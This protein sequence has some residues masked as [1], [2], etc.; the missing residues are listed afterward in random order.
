[1]ALRPAPKRTAHDNVPRREE[2]RYLLTVLEAAQKI[3]STSDLETLL[4]KIVNEIAPVFGCMQCFVWLCEDASGDLVLAGAPPAKGYTKGTRL[5]IGRE[6]LVGHVAATGR[7]RYTPD[8]RRDPLYV[9]ASRRFDTR[10]ELDLP[11]ICNNRVIGVLNTE[12][13]YV[14]GF[15]VRQRS[16]LKR[17]ADYTATAVE[18]A[19]ASTRDQAEKQEARELQMR[20]LPKGPLVAGNYEL[21]GRCVPSGVV[22]GDWFDYFAIGS[23]RVAVALA[24]V[25]GKGLAAALLMSSS[26]M[27][28]RACMAQTSRPSEVL[29]M[30][31]RFLVDD[32]PPAR[33]VTLVFGVL[34][35]RTGEF[36]F[37]NA[38]HP[39]PLLISDS[40]TF[41]RTQRGLPL[42]MRESEYDDYSVT[43]TP[44]S[45]LL[46]YSDGIWEASNSAEDEFGAAHL[47]E[48]SAQEWATPDS[49]LESVFAFTGCRALKDDATAVMLRA[50]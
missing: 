13:K 27:L 17:L 16:A 19:R 10:S 31:N 35:L 25:A 15:D 14:D 36:M 34:D 5:R 24:D 6:G 21:Q 37:A 2:V 38:G 44:G 1:M 33:F 3:S 26:R 30:M 29:K 18:N 12:S 8:V 7:M 11:L 20:L 40:Q 9:D 39:E 41:L 50:A 43:L 22:G 4:D 46:F 45:R 48:A 49:L 47:L 32:L 23:D 42:G 28:L